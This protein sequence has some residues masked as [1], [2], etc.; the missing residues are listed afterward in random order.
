[1]DSIFEFI[2]N[3]LSKITIEQL[4]EKLAIIIINR[5]L[6]ETSTRLSIGTKNWVFL[7]EDGR[8]YYERTN[9]VTFGPQDNRWDSIKNLLLDLDFI[10]INKNRLNITNKGIEWL[11]RIE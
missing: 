5:H 6:H 10:Y 3:N 7:E 8:L 4:I 9:L 1:M 11:K 2:Q